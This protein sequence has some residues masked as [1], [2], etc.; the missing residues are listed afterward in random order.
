MFKT[1]FNYKVLALKSDRVMKTVN[2][3][4]NNGSEIFACLLDYQKTFNLVNHGKLFRILIKRR[5]KL[6]FVRILIFI[7]LNQKCYI[8]WNG[9]RSYSF[10]VTN[11]TRQGSIFSPQGGFSSYLDPLLKSLKE[12]GHG[13]RIG[14]HYYGAHAYADD[15]I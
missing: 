15:V 9:V 10:S 5:M 7:Y 14:L 12:S 13:C 11:G 8:K 1:Y 3:F 2:N 4:K 6:I